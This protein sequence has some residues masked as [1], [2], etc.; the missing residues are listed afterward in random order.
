[1]G[2]STRSRRRQDHVSSQ[3]EAVEVGRLVEY[4][5]SSVTSVTYHLPDRA[6]GVTTM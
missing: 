4:G 2:R 3:T 1:M 6:Q 5:I